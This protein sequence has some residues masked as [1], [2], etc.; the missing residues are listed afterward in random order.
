MPFYLFLSLSLGCF[1]FLYLATNGFNDWAA[2]SE[3]RNLKLLLVFSPLVWSFFA[4][5][6]IFFIIQPK[7]IEIDISKRIMVC[8]KKKITFDELKHLTIWPVQEVEEKKLYFYNIKYKTKKMSLFS[9][10][11]YLKYKSEKKIELLEPSLS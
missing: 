5:T 11:Y 9:T 7:R 2:L 1:V 8:D 6:L 10:W 4:Y 3:Q